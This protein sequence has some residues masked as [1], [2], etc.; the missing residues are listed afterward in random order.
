VTPGLTRSFDIASTVK[1]RLT[2][3]VPSALHSAISVILGSEVSAD[4][5]SLGLPLD[6]DLRGW[7]M[8]YLDPA[9]LARGVEE[10]MVG[11]VEIVRPVACSPILAGHFH[12][13]RM[14]CRRKTAD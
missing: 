14:P 1:P 13:S 4:E 11:A 8:L 10:E 12:F 6:G 7:R 3:G 9:V 5:N 2:R